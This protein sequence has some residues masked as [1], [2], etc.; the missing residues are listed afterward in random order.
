MYPVSNKFM[1]EVQKNT[2][3][4]YWT[5]GITTKTNQTY[6]FG[7][8]DIVKG[9]GYITRQ[10]CGSTEIELG[11]V[12]AA[13]MGISLYSDVDR[14]WT[15]QRFGYHSIWCIWTEPKKKCRWACLRSAKQTELS[16]AWN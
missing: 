1:E 9:S 13:E 2:R 10:C 12:Y 7:N 6:E 14:Y 4:F 8:D 5:G 11:T 15:E 3:T 16:V